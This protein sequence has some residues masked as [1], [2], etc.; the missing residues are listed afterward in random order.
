MIDIAADWFLDTL[1]F[2][3]AAHAGQ[4]DKAG[5]PYIEHV[6]RV[7]LRLIAMFPDVTPEQVQA[8]LLHDVVEDTPATLEEVQSR[9]GAEVAATVA[10]L[11]K[12]PGAVYADYIATL[13]ATG[14]VD[15][16]RVKL[17]D[18]LDNSDPIRVHLQ[19]KQMV[20]ERYAPARAVLKAALARS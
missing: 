8:A 10:A 7:A 20:R 16:L 4:V 18:N 19:Q 15:A 5:Q 3:K 17:A 12:P 13:A 6:K 1:A 2:A 11:T 9:F 14:H